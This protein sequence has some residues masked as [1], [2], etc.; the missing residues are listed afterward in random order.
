MDQYWSTLATFDVVH[1]ISVQSFPV[2]V[3][4]VDELFD[5]VVV[6][7]VDSVASDPERVAERPEA[8]SVRNRS[9]DPEQGQHVSIK[10]L[11]LLQSEASAV[12]EGSEALQS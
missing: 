5:V 1:L 2:D 7:G 3:F 12:A 11:E 8:V 4:I 10:P 6:V 9:L